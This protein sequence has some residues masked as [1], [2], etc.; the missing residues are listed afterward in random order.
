MQIASTIYDHQLSGGLLTHARFGVVT[1][2]RSTAVSYRKPAGRVN[3]VPSFVFWAT[4]LILHVCALWLF[5]PVSWFPHPPVEQKV[6]PARLVSLGAMSASE[7]SPP[8]PPP[9]SK[10]KPLPGARPHFMPALAAVPA[11]SVVV[12]LPRFIVT[13]APASRWVLLLPPKLVDPMEALELPPLPIRP[14]SRPLPGA[15]PHFMP[16]LASTPVPPVTVPLPRAVE[17]S[18]T[19][20]SW[21]LWVPTKLAG[22]G[23]VASGSPDDAADSSGML[24]AAGSQDGA[25]G[26]NGSAS[27]A[28]GGVSGSQGDASG[29]HGGASNGTGGSFALPAYRQTPL[30]AYPFLAKAR[31]WE[32]VTLLRVEVLTDGRVGR[33]ELVASSGHAELDESAIRAVHGWRFEPAMR[34]DTAIASFIQVPIRFKLNR[35]GA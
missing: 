4:S 3:G 24:A 5:M 31:G 34:G 27:G 1:G 23:N 9:L 12:P 33:V 15:R 6:I 11:P 10:S 21:G 18:A 35:S 30:P 2:T 13:S 22:A 7:L 17:A 14:Q 26:S 16:A 8:P 32:G 28:Q 29:S 20:S 25:S 19:A